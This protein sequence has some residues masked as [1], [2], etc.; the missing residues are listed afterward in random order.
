MRIPLFCLAALAAGSMALVGCSTAPETTQ[1][2]HQ[3]TSDAKSSLSDLTAQDPGLNDLLK[4]SYGY[5]IFPSVGK[6]AAGIGAS[7]GRGE[8]WAN[9]KLVGYADMTQATIGA[10]LGG[11]TYAEL[12]VFRTDVALQRFESAQ[13]TFSANAS[14]VAVKAGAAAAARWDDDIVVFQD[15]KGGLMADASIGGQKF[16]FIPMGS[17]NNNNG[18]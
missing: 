1:E 13:F 17:E 4:N 11:Q 5:A 18:Q 14:A 2:R 9:G 16:N 15:V 8:V 3:L 6:G 10:S 7:Y 12:I